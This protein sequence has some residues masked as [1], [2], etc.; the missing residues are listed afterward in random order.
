MLIDIDQ[1]IEIDSHNFFSPNHPIF[2][3]FFID[4]RKAFQVNFG[5]KRTCEGTERDTEGVGC[6]MS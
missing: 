4:R 2:I 5:I 1:S 6:D 3:A